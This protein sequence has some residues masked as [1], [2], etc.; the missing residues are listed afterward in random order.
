MPIKLTHDITIN[1]TMN[2][3]DL[4]IFIDLINAVENEDFLDFKR[5]Y[6]M[7]SIAHIRN[8]F[9]KMFNAI[10]ALPET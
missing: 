6:N 8:K 5:K 1:M 4:E 9:A 2:Y 10:K 3:S 7:D